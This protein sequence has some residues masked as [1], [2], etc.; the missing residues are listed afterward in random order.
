[1][2][3]Y[4]TNLTLCLALLVFSSATLS[5]EKQTILA[6]PGAEGF[7]AYA[8]GGR[9]GQVYTV[10][11]LEDSGPGSFRR[12]VEQ[13]GPR[14]IVF[15]I[16]G[17]ISLKENITI[18]NPLITIAGQTAPGDGICLKDAQFYIAT[19]D[20]IVR[21]IRCRLGDRGKDGDAIGVSKGRNI[22]LD[23]CS[24]SWSTDEVLSCSTG[25]PTL[26]DVTVQWCFI[27]EALD[28]KN[29][30]YGSLIRGT[31]GARYSYHHNLYA[32]NRSRNPRPGNY[33]RNPHTVDPEGFFLDFRNNVIY[34][35]AGS[36][37]G[38]NADKESVTKLN[39]IGNFLIPGPNSR[40][41]GKAYRTGSPYNRSYF[42]NN[43]Y[44]GKKPIDQWRLVLFDESW[45][46]ETIALYK[47]KRP[48]DTESIASED[49]WTAYRRVMAHGGASR[50]TRDEID[51]RI[52]DDVQRRMGKIINSQ[53]DVGGWPQLDHLAPPVDS[54]RD[55]MPDEWETIHNLNPDGPEDCNGDRDRD[56]YT[57]L[58]EYLNNLCL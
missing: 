8:K 45:K 25:N 15:A 35:W 44:D 52:V 13:E 33:D 51:I 4:K 19:S 3:Y 31:G 26:T 12:A 10:T 32:H 57:N 29:H 22:I 42:A 2:R 48:F 47:Q 43:I 21:Y 24:A 14:T 36:Y 17:T 40:N 7:G 1:M 5:S 38:Y 50:P 39:Y 28:P 56:G 23:H 55:G 54:D 20:V 41:T 53:D 49:A 34:N 46:P 6:F 11:T 58:E 30:G 16:S 27:T 9:G 18:R 37:P